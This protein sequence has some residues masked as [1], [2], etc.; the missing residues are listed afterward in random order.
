MSLSYCLRP[1]ACYL[2]NLSR[3]SRRL[4]GCCYRPWCDACRII[5]RR[6]C[7]RLLKQRRH[8]LLLSEHERVERRILLGQSFHR[9]RRVHTRTIRCVAR[10]LSGWLLLRC[11]NAWDVR[12]LCARIPWRARRPR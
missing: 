9:D 10:C 11:D 6:R 4:D 12:V 2:R 3:R 1:R 7:T 8:L 5:G